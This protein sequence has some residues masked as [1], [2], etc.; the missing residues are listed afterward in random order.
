MRSMQRG[1]DK[2][3]NNQEEIKFQCLKEFESKY[4]HAQCRFSWQAFFL[5]GV[6]RR[7]IARLVAT[8]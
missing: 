8:A 3:M 6:E 1:H 5:D 2:G 7:V 4:S